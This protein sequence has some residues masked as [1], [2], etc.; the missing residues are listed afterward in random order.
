MYNG[1]LPLKKLVTS[2]TLQ[3]IGVDSHLSGLSSA[4]TT[5]L[6]I[7]SY[8]G[9]AIYEGR[10]NSTIIESRILSWQIFLKGN[11]K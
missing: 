8:I 3:I 11:K 2:A 6:M 9:C 10:Q 7:Y 5:G 4:S 1:I